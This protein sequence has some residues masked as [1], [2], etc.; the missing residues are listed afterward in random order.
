MRC[1]NSWFSRSIWFWNSWLLRLH[2]LKVVLSISVNQEQKRINA[3][4]LGA[5]IRFENHRVSAAPQF[6]ALAKQCRT[7]FKPSVETDGW[8]CGMLTQQTRG[9][10][11]SESIVRVLELLLQLSEQLGC[12]RPANAW[13]PGPPPGGTAGLV[14]RACWG[15]WMAFSCR[16]PVP[17]N[18]RRD[19][20]C[21]RPV[22]DWQGDVRRRYRNLNIVIC[23]QPGHLHQQVVYAGIRF[24]RM[25]FCV[26]HDTEAKS[27]ENGKMSSLQNVGR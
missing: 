22:C 18:H 9:G 7:E 13:F 12:K 27:L 15:S 23:K 3:G 16:V 10:L 14:D 6:P 24:D 5:A 17:G 25:S 19:D 11:S 21:S 2:I 4:C 1:R 26:G 8:C 20:A